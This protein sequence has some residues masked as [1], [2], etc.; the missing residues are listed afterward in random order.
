MKR[1]TFTLIEL[2]VVIA[3]IAILAAMLLPALRGAR[4][5]AKGA[6]CLNN[7]KQIILANIMYAGDNGDWIANI[8]IPY[9]GWGPE[10]WASCITGASGRK[11]QYIPLGMSFICPSS[12][13]MP[14]YSSV[15]LEWYTYGMYRARKDI[16]YAAKGYDFGDTITEDNAHYRIDKIPSPSSFVLIADTVNISANW[17]SGRPLWQFSPSNDCWEGTYVHL[18]HSNQASSS[19]VDGHAA[20]RSSRALR[21]SVTA[22]KFFVNKNGLVIS[23]P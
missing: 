21:E 2:L 10:P 3:I 12:N 8:Y 6:T 14:D 13:L 22:I 7:Q 15:Q 4:D 19:F 18:I 17:Y 9:P 16:E 11:T 20:M 5:M 1:K 23:E